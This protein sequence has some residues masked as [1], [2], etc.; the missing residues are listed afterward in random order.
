MK[1]KEILQFWNNL[2]SVCEVWVE[3]GLLETEY[4]VD[5]SGV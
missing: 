1:L 5:C 2:C 3:G 4:L